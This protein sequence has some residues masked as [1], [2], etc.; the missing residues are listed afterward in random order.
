MQAE[1]SLIEKGAENKEATTLLK[2][3]NI[4]SIGWI[5]ILVPAFHLTSCVTFSKTNLILYYK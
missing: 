4:I 2:S 3:N 5:L 1:H